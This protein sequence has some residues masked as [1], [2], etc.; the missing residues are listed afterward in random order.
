MEAIT[1]IELNQLYAAKN[2]RELAKHPGIYLLP[3]VAMELANDKDYG[4]RNYLAL[5]PA[6]AQLP[7]VAMALAGNER[8]TVS[9]W[10][11]LN[12]AIAQMP[13]VILELDK[14]RF[15]RQYL[16]LNPALAEPEI[17]IR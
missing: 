4:V 7:E 17:P 16:A 3:E 9:A 11:A 8:W 12:P 1:I 14:D 10:L 13:E 2:F 5:N 15:V 6:I